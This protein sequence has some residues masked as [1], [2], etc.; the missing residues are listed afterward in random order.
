[1]TL[2]EER[3]QELIAALEECRDYF[4]TRADVTDDGEGRPQANTEL[5]LWEQID[6]TLARC[7][8]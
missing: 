8:R 2:N 3:I 6:A 1:M 4:D 7:K 5:R